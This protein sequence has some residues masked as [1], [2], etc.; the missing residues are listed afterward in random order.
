MSWKAV[1]V[2][3]GMIEPVW[4][5]LTAGNSGKHNEHKDKRTAKNIRLHNDLASEAMRVQS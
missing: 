5:L 2:E 1:P 3:S 4:T